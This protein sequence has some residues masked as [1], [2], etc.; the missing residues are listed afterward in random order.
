MV[1]ALTFFKNSF[2][3]AYRCIPAVLSQNYAKV[4][5]SSQVQHDQSMDKKLAELTGDPTDEFIHLHDTTVSPAG[6]PIDEELCVREDSELHKKN[7]EDK[8]PYGF[9]DL[10]G[11]QH[12]SDLTLKLTDGDM[13]VHR[14][15]LH[16]SSSYFKKLF[17]ES[18]S[19]AVMDMSSYNPLAYR[20]FLQYLYKIP[21]IE[22]ECEDM[23]DLYVLATSYEEDWI[24][25]DVFSKLKSSISPDNVLRLLDKAKATKST[26]LELECHKFINAPEFKKS[27]LEFAS[28]NMD[29][30][31]EI[32][33][34]FSKSRS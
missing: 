24:A 21:I 28:E 27:L 5:T 9:H 22:M 17:S 6:K 16:S 14:C 23:I 12:L 10:F 7:A 30:L 31:T 19:P 15:V 3:S 32:L 13:P 4:L 29:V 34:L 20:G 2:H 11:Q 1:S 18:I 26:E 25:A 8:N 33:R